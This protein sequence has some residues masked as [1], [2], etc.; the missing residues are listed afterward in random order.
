MIRKFS[1][2]SEV[3]AAYIQLTDDTVLDSEEIANGIVVDYNDR[4]DIVAIEL[5]DTKKI[6]PESFFKLKSLLPES[7][8]TML[9]EF[10][11]F[12]KQLC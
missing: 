8:I 1:Y 3:D 2:D 11:L 4:D 6:T 7:T 12:S 10:N 9:Q 5:L